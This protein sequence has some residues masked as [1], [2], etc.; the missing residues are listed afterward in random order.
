MK[1]IECISG[2]VEEEIADAK[3]YVKKALELK[4]DR[5][6]LAD[7]FYSLSID[8]MRHMSILHGEVVKIIEDYRKTTGE[9]PAAMLAVY[10]YLHKK[11]VE[12]ASEVKLLQSMY[13]E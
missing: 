13:K 9:P 6:N 1:L 7:V 11:Q 2:M 10:E 5:R 3:K 4:E 8:E 12:A